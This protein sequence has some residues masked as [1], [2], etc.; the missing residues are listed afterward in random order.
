M[1]EF[2]SKPW[3][4]DVDRTAA[5]NLLKESGVNRGCVVRPT[6]SRSDALAVTVLKDNIVT[7]SIIIIGGK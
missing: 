4:H 6:S 3:F 2:K 7:H 1:T 5:E